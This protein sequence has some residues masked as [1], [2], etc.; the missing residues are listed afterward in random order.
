[1]TSKLLII[2]F[3]MISC[4]TVNAQAKKT[5]KKKPVSQEVTKPTFKTEQ[6]M[7][8]WLYQDSIKSA[9]TDSLNAIK[10]SVENINQ[11]NRISSV[12]QQY[13]H[14]KDSLSYIDEKVTAIIQLNPVNDLDSA[15]VLINKN[16]K[17]TFQRIR[18]IYDWIA[19]K[20][21]YDMN[22][23]TSNT[24]EPIDDDDD[25][26]H[27]TFGSGKGVCQN[28]ANLFYYMC[29][30]SGL[31]ATVIGG[32]GKNFPYC[33]HPDEEDNHAWNAVKTKKGWMLIDVTWAAVDTGRIDNYWFNTP[34]DQFIYSHLPSDSS[35]QFSKKKISREQFLNYPIVSQ[36]LFLSK[37][38]FDIP[39]Q[40]VFHYVVD[41]FS[42]SIPASE[43]SYTVSYSILPYKDDSWS[44]YM[45]M[46]MQP[47]ETTTVIDKKEKT[48]NYETHIPS[49]GTW[50]LAI[51]LNKKISN[52]DIDE[53]SFPQ[54]ILLKIIY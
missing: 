32:L 29:N 2:S 43:T 45:N 18:A 39:E 15:V 20:V 9:T 24:I 17:T 49:R 3:S 10:D 42:I 14:P 28:Y 23:F 50:W 16:F 54:A 41:K 19:L 27:K 6:E 40:G 7:Q 52:K 53:I 13:W 4:V 8:Q 12:Y 38:D 51:N 33:I 35:M 31:E 21:R 47:L 26:A 1:M 48:V 11:L 34:A 46:N 5:I 22:A 37:L 36:F 25:D 30:K 44:S